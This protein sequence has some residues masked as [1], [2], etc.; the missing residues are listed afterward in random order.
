MT[1]VMD[2]NMREPIRLRPVRAWRTYTGGRMLDALHGIQGTRDGHY[3]EEWILSVV[4]ARNACRGASGD[5]GLSLVEGTG[6]TLRQLI[7]SQGAE[8]LGSRHVQR[9]GVTP[10]VLVKLIDAAERLTVQVHPDKQAARTLFDSKYGKTECWHILGSR[11]REGE[12]PCIYLGFRPSITREKWKQCF[13]RQDIAGMLA[14]LHRFPVRA[15]ET[16]LIEGGVPHAIGEGCFLM[17]IQ[18]PTDYSI[19][20]ERTT[21]GGLPVVDSLCHQGLGFDR[22]FD[23]FH[24]SGFS[25]RDTLQRWQIPPRIIKSNEA[26]TETELI[27]YGNTSCFRMNRIEVRGR[28]TLESGDIYSGLYVLSG[29]GM[30]RCIGGVR[31]LKPGDQFLI[32]ANHDSFA[33]EKTGVQPLIVVRLCGP[34]PCA[35]MDDCTIS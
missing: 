21:P 16:Y 18:E 4:T 34:D 19:R 35:A 6:I 9:Y 17:E 27:G 20:T 2:I 31:P 26:Y 28:I 15:G 25:A 29:C 30:L 33:L 10:G 13:D 32:P 1:G 5:E 12:P 23:C 3:P 14:C 7:E 24:Y 22:M 8:L 11:D